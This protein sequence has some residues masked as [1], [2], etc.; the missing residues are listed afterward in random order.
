MS[1]ATSRRGTARGVFCI[2]ICILHLYLYL[3]LYLGV[4]VFCICTPGVFVFW[5]Y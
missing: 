2:C 1:L 5:V 4:S 3:Y